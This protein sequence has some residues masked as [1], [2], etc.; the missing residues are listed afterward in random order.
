MASTMEKWLNHTFS[1]GS[2]TGQDY[3]AFQ[4]VARADLRK[5]AKAAGYALH[6]F[7]PN[8]YEFSAVLRDEITG[9]FVYI[10]ISDVR[11][12]RNEWYTCVLYRTMAHDKD[13]TDSSNQ[14]C[15]WPEIPQ[16]LKRMRMRRYGRYER[17]DSC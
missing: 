5:Q 2:K 8:H 15:C 14:Y 1:S 3:A 6:E 11:Y 12:S 13:W 7:N 16:V 10:A 4:R 9:K 17:Q